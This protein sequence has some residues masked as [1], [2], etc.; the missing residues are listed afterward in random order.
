MKN[1]SIKHLIVLLACCGMSAGAIGL[2][3]NA[4]GVFYGPVAQ[5][6]G[7]GRG[8]FALHMTF[9]SLATAFASLITAN[10]VRRLPLKVV[11]WTS[12][13]VCAATFYLS[14]MC[15]QVYQFYVLSAI[16][17]V[18]VTLFSSIPITMIINSWF[19][20][21]HGLVTSIVFSFSGIIGSLFAPIFTQIIADYGWGFGY[22]FKAIFLILFS[23]PALLYP[24]HLDPQQDG[25]LPFGYEGEEE[26]VEVITS[27]SKFSFM[28]ASFFLF[29]IFSVLVCSA[30]NLSQHFPGFATSINYS[31]SVGAMLVSAVMVGNIVSKLIIG[32]LSDLLGAIKAT[33]IMLGS[34]FVGMVLLLLGL[35]STML[36]LGAFLFGASYSIGAVGIPLLTKHFFSQE[37]YNQVFPVI[38]FANGIGGA[39]SISLIGFV[40][41]LFHSYALALYFG[42]AVA[43]LGI[44]LISSLNKKVDN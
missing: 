7:V 40:Y 10:V 8:T 1:K 38:T 17:G 34:M 30:T 26:R 33:Y 25:V 32:L 41:D 39:L 19:K 22:V 3:I 36:L 2:C 14:A 42:V 29:T 11:L 28:Q 6:L 23:L 9:F 24:F 35:N 31:A 18:F 5:T 13:I 21:S 15:T 37:H 43:I 12:V 4:S 44:M 20:K 27:Q 16:R